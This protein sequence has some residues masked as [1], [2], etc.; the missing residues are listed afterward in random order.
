MAEALINARLGE[1][2]QA[3]SAGT[4]PTGH[5]H[6]KALEVLREI[7]IRHQGY[8]KNVVQFQDANLDLVLTVCDSAAESCPVW[9][10]K[11]K[12]VHISFPDPA[13]AIGT[14]EQIL[15]VF[16]EVRDGIEEK[17]LGYL[18]KF[19]ENTRTQK[20]PLR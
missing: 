4:E 7:G 5:V 10:G 18:K 17:V 19:P 14:Q 8:S 6:P 1:T 16:R 3:F 9:L 2:W 15:N 20:N 13:K 12:R 11:G